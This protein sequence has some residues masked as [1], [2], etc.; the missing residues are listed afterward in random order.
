MESVVEDL[1]EV[2]ALEEILQPKQIVQKILQISRKIQE[3]LAV[4]QQ[5][6]FDIGQI[7][8]TLVNQVF[9]VCVHACFS[10][11]PLCDQDKSRFIILFACKANN[12]CV[13]CV[14]AFN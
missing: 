2:A 14:G 5:S 13:S 7:G 8:L 9:Y 12:Y 6:T 3:L 1:P 11:D 4:N 10:G